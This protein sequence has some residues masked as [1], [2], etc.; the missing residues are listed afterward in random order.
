MAE[1]IE[2]AGEVKSTDVFYV[3]PEGEASGEIEHLQQVGLEIEQL[4]DS[5][6]S[7]SI[8]MRKISA[9]GYSGLNGIEIMLLD[10]GIPPRRITISGD[11]LT[12]SEV[13]TSG[14]ETENDSSPNTLSLNSPRN[15]GRGNQLHN[16]IEA[17]YQSSDNIPLRRGH[18][19]YICHDGESVATRTGFLDEFD[20]LAASEYADLFQDETLLG[21]TYEGHELKI[22]TQNHSQAII[23]YGKSVGFADRHAVTED[24]PEEIKTMISAIEDEETRN[25]VLELHSR[26]AKLAVEHEVTL[27]DME[28]MEALLAHNKVLLRDERNKV[29]TLEREVEKLKSKG[30][31][32][33]DDSDW[34]KNI[35]GG[36]AGR[37]GTSMETHFQTIGLSPEILNAEPALIVNAAKAMRKAWAKSLHSDVS[38]KDDDAL[39][40]INSS[41][42]SIVEH[43]NRT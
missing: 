27:G 2:R 24:I 39:K 36:N 3:N 32:G 20:R 14:Y 16:I 10:Y 35:L 15:D 21:L 9:G 5:N 6:P 13:R 38:G 34:L 28:T 31:G 18:S 41:V 30:N 26:L 40:A 1:D 37:S 43:F 19:L 29:W 25:A 17:K 33:A 4:S 42:D 22:E 12:P 7:L 11:F 23:M 8:D